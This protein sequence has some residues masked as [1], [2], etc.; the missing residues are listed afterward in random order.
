MI[1][2]ITGDIVDSRKGD[3]EAWL[4][5]LKSTLNLYGTEPENWMLFRGDSFQLSLAPETAFLA[6]LHVKATIKQIKPY[7][8]RMAIGL[9][10]KSYDSLSIA[11]SNG[12]AFVNSG[13]CFEGLK[14]YTL[15]LKSDYREFD[16]LMNIMIRISLLTIE[17]WSD[18]VSEVIKAVIDHPGKNQKDLAK[19]LNKSQSNISEALKRG[20]FEEIMNVNNYYSRM[21]LDL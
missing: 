3:I 1:A 9:G 11:E 6:A 21:V 10:E 4:I 18:V 17:N 20:G 5:P 2:V 19:L 14:K 8:V 13:E 15:A 16:D 7:N 12:S